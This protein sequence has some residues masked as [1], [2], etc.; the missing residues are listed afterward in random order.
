MIE[1]E[2]VVIID[3]G[4]TNVKF[5]IFKH[6]ELE[7]V[8]IITY[9]DFMSDTHFIV[10]SG[11]RGAISSVL[12]EEKNRL[13]QS[14]FPKLKW[15]HTQSITQMTNHYQSKTLGID[16]WC[17]VL[18][19]QFLF[20]NVRSGLVVDVGTCVK[21]DFFHNRSYLGGAISPGVRMRYMSFNDYTDNLPLLEPKST[22]DFIAD[23]T[24]HALHVGVM[25]GI[26]NEIKGFIE[27]YSKNYQNLT[28]IITGGDAKYFDLQAKNSIFAIE[29]LTLY[30]IYQFFLCQL[31]TN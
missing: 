10:E 7:S 1:N 25:K 2:R 3:A 22:K 24:D 30:G 29:N 6:Q 20:P 21:Y 14:K 28:V 5:A 12:S 8:S 19:M 11:W 18:G 4:N 26:E 17:N 27:A 16:R 9:E 23:Q 31:E 13:I 15:V